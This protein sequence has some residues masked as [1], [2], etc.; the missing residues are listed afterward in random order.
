M[1]LLLGLAVAVAGALLI[2]DFAAPRPR[3]HVWGELDSSDVAS[4][5]RRRRR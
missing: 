1:D 2:Y 3:R 5:L 4:S